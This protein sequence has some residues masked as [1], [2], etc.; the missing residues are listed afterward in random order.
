MSY[1]EANEI[2]QYYEEYSEGEPVLLLHGLG[3]SILDW[4]LQ[5]VEFS[6]DF[7]VITLDL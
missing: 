5:I 7:K 4:E 6:T 3:L 1:I 2:Q